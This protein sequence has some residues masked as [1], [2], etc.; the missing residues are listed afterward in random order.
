V[1]LF[2]SSSKVDGIEN[3]HIYDYNLQGLRVYQVKQNIIFHVNLLKL[4]LVLLQGLAFSGG[5]FLH[6]I[7]DHAEHV[8]Y[9][10]DK[11]NGS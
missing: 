1:L 7:L 10:P 5:K 4:F 8:G 11:G 2:T 6:N 9:I 3:F